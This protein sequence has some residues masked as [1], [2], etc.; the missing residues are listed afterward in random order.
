M[1]A[2]LAFTHLAPKMLSYIARYLAVYYASYITSGW[3]MVS[4][5][6]PGV[7]ATFASTPTGSVDLA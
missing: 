2:L 6:T 4:D 7:D 1:I 3:T 5:V